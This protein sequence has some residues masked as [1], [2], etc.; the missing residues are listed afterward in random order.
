MSI[1]NRN[2][3]T[4]IRKKD[5]MYSSDKITTLPVLPTSN[6]TAEQ[7]RNNTI[8]R[9]RMDPSVLFVLED[10][11]GKCEER[12]ALDAGYEMVITLQDGE[13]PAASILVALSGETIYLQDF[14]PEQEEEYW[15]FFTQFLG[16]VKWI[17]G[18]I[19]R[20]ELEFLD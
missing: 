2:N 20:G 13:E 5:G 12:A 19:D 1:F 17:L 18:C 16:E 15:D 14:I 9:L 3:V 7:N 4:V 10:H 11:D 6:L 8:A